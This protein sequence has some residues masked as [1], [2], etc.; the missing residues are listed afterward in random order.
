MNNFGIFAKVTTTLF[1]LLTP[2]LILYAI[3]NRTSV[4]LLTDEIM[5]VKQNQIETFASQLDHTLLQLDTY[6]KM[7]YESTDVRNLAY[8]DL[9]GDVLQKYR[10]VRTVSEEINRLAGY[11]DWK[12]V[13]AVSYPK[14][15]NV[16]KSNSSLN[17]LPG[18]LPDEDV[19]WQFFDDP[20]GSYFMEVLS[21]P[22]S[23]G[24]QEE[25]DMRVVVKMD[26]AEIRSALSDFK[27]NGSGDPFLYQPGNAPI[28][29]YSSDQELSGELLAGFRP[30]ISSNDEGYFMSE[31]GD[32]SYQI[33]YQKVDSLGWY[34]VDYVPISQIMAPIERNRT[35]FYAISSMMLFMAIFL[36]FFIYRNVQ[37]PFRKLMQSMNLIEKGIYSSRMKD[38]PKGEFRFLYD[39][40]NSMATRIEALIEDVFKEQL[41]SKEAT[42]KHLQSQINPHF[43]YNTL[44][45]IKSMIELEERDAAIAMTMSL[46]KYYRYTTKT[47]K[48]LATLEEELEMTSHYL[49]INSSLM[50]GFE[51]EIHVDP[52]MLEMEVPRLI[53]QPLIENV[54]LHGFKKQSSFGMIRI[55]GSIDGAFARL[56]VED[57]GVGIEPAAMDAMNVKIRTAINEE[58]ESGMQNVHQRMKL[59]Y[60]EG[61]GLVLRKSPLGGVCAE[62]SW[63]CSEIH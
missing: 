26:V 44:A 40:F 34:V 13:I 6:Q 53:V 24:T 31:A 58:I 15:G 10:T 36:A 49:A 35:M 1:I 25:A 51:Y 30:E 9:L 62:L 55:Q 18:R 22:R 39:R 48:K 61:S 5:K 3:S 33:H 43:L 29:N 12:A 63:K 38:K 7:L 45:Y 21:Y 27:T 32:S 20:A 14:A 52:Q 19:L 41:R 60:G 28:Y 4:G 46:S 2:I 37:I 56:T 42:L 57:S 23:S 50:D 59:L 47:G 16:I 8:P 54:I 11:G 17:A